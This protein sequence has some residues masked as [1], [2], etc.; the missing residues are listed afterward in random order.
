MDSDTDRK[1]NND[2]ETVLLIDAWEDQ[3]ALDAHYASPMMQTIF[4]LR[5]KYDLHMTV[6]RYASSE[7]EQPDEER[8]IRE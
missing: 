2:C 4:V 7:G 6:E 1:G 5:E 8:F 3:A